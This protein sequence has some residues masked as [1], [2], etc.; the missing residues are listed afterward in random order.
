[1]NVFLFVPQAALAASAVYTFPFVSVTATVAVAS[2]PSA[3]A[4]TS[5]LFMA[6]PPAGTTI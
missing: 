2:P 5:R 4:T 1:L 3:I 6:T